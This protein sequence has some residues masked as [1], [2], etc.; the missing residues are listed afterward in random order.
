MMPGSDSSNGWCSLRMR[1]D[2]RQLELLRCAETLRGAAY[3]QTTGPAMLRTALNLA[4]AGRKLAGTVAGGSVN[5][6]EAELKLLVDALRFS[7]REIQ[8]ASR[9]PA[10]ARV[11]AEAVLAAFPELEQQ[12]LWRSFGVVRELDALAVHLETALKG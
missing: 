9:A 1:F 5:L 10:S 3:A 11:Q 8:A 4:R 6:E 2:A 7:S 12:G